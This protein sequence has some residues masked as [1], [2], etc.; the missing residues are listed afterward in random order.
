M[1]RQLAGSPQPVNLPTY[2][3]NEWL[4]LTSV[5]VSLHASI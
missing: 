4:Y 2:R 1:F 3:W 5:G